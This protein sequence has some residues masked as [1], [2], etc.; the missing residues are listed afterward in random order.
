MVWHL[1]ANSDIAAGV[2]DA[3]VDFRK[4]LCTTYATLEASKVVGVKRIAFASTS[5]VYG[6]RCDLL[7][8]ESGP[9]LPISNYGA[10]KL[11]SEAMLS[12]AVESHLER[13]WIFRFPNVIGPRSTHGAIHDFVK[14]LTYNSGSLNVLGDGTQRKPYL[15]V[16]ELVDAMR[17]IVARA[18]ESRNVFN[19]GPLGEGT[20]VSFLAEQTVER[21][22]PGSAIAY[23]G[24]DR[25][26]VGD[27]PR[28]SY[29]VAKLAALGWVPNLSSDA[30]ALRAINEI[31]ADLGL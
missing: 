17:F 28:F 3:S 7:T 20:Y 1:A 14:R 12:A 4:T 19:I 26:W 23:A 27:V 13:I 15:H 2:A 16:S 30:A 18:D 21:V 25:G 9:L 6:E 10:A 11:A 29:G 8:E 5:A 22:A 31:A 24:G